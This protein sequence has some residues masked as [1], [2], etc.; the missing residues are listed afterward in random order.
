MQFWFPPPDPEK[1]PCP[2]LAGFSTQIVPHVPPPPFGHRFYDNS[3]A[4][5]RPSPSEDELRSATQSEAV[6]RWPVWDD[7]DHHTNSDAARAEGKCERELTIVRTLRAGDDVG[8]QVVV[9]RVRGLSMPTYEKAANEY[10]VKGDVEEGEGEMVV[11]AKI[12]DPLYYSFANRIATHTPED[13]VRIADGEYAREATAYERLERVSGRSLP[14]HL[15]RSG[16]GDGDRDDDTK[17]RHFAPRYHG[18]WTFSLPLG[19]GHRSVR[20]IL[21]EYL[22][23]KDM[24]AFE[25][26]QIGYETEGP[27]TWHLDRRF[28]LDVV[29]GVLEAWN[30]LRGAGIWHRDLEG[31][32]MLVVGEENPRVLVVD[33]G[34]AVVWDRTTEEARMR[35]HR[36]PRGELV[37]NP[38]ETFWMGVPRQVVGWVPRG[39]DREGNL[40]LW[41]EWLLDRF[42]EGKTARRFEP[43]VDSKLQLADASTMVGVEEPVI[44]EPGPERQ[45]FKRVAPPPEIRPG[46]VPAVWPVS[47]WTGQNPLGSEVP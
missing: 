6:L 36:P 19:T 31:R 13:V 24:C 18:A 10:R 5:S 26:E 34:I 35:F 47:F 37:E 16:N 39:W 43:V 29:A 28:R 44:Q 27:N 15:R 38:M 1:P 46:E 14:Q 33:Y 40:R 45:R 9:C 20:L 4:Y 22:K 30:W 41:Q 11:A 42:G 21:L 23:G 3:A 17:T 2:Y 12:Y 8:A 7:R 32:N 25:R